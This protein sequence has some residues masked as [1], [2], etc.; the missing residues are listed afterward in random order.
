MRAKII[1]FRRTW[2]WLGNIGVR[3]CM[4]IIAHVWSTNSIET[5]QRKR[6][7]CFQSI[8]FDWWRRSNYFKFRPEAVIAK[9]KTDGWTP[10]DGLI[11]DDAMPARDGDLWLISSAPRHSAEKQLASPAMAWFR[12]LAALIRQHLNLRLRLLDLRLVELPAHRLLFHPT[13]TATI[14]DNQFDILPYVAAANE[15]PKL[16]RSPKGK[17]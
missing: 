5:R 9:L 8:I 7:I 15:L 2:S 3:R 17:I 4:S 14:N 13:I 1:A 10:G 11:L 6:A 12:E 16:K